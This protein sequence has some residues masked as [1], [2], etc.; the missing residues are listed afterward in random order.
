MEEKFLNEF[1]E[2]IEIENEEIIEE[3][4]TGPSTQNSV[5]YYC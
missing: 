1:F 2:E 5:K 4:I 3:E